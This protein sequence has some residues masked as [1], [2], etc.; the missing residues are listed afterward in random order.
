MKKTMFVLTCL[1][2]ITATSFAQAT[3]IY[4]IIDGKGANIDSALSDLLLDKDLYL[5]KFVTLANVM[6]PE[7]GFNARKVTFFECAPWFDDSETYL[8]RDTRMMYSKEMSF[9]FQP[10]KTDRDMRKAMLDFVGK[11]LINPQVMTISGRFVEHQL[12]TG[13]ILYLFLVDSFELL[14]KKYTGAIPDK[15]TYK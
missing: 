2:L 15:V 8:F 12:S 11:Y 10:T 13:L 5:D 9:Y 6:Y 4:M 3:D 1:L 7:F 14:G